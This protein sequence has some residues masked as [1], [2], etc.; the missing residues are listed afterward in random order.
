MR[1][2]VK[3]LE[4]ENDEE[5]VSFLDRLGKT[6][7]SILAYHYPFYRDM[8]EAIGVG[9]AIYLGAF[10]D[11]SLVGILPTFVRESEVGAVYNS[12]PYFGPNAG[13]IC[14]SDEMCAE[15]HSVLLETLLNFAAQRNTLSCSIYTPFRSDQFALYDSVMP[16]AIVIDKFTQYL[17]LATA[18][19][20]SEINYDLRKASRMG[21]Q[22]STEISPERIDEFFAIYKQNCRDYG[23]PLKPRRGVDLL[24]EP[25]IRDQHS[26]IYFAIQ[27][28]RMIAGL[29]VLWSPVTASYYIPCTLATARA[30]QPGTFLIDRAVQDAR[31]RGIRFWNW[32]SSPSRDSGVYRFKEKWGSAEGSYRIYVQ[33][34]YPLEKFQQLGRE[35]IARDFPF[36]FVYPFDLL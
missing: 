29:L 24:L 15:I 25:N 34:F 1:I 6:T 16:S 31:A 28:G 20:S 21:V 2:T 8:L 9:K 23:I 7:T 22:V 30:L 33:S 10:G 35:A 19:W 18:V 26:S 5:F 36:Y 13:V 27:N 17:D 3:K 32:E 12:L 11:G 14:Q 4:R